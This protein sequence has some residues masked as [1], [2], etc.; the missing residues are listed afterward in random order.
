MQQAPRAVPGQTYGEAGAQIASQQVVPL[1][2]GGGMAPPTSGA[3]MPG[4]IDA[5]SARPNEPLTAG[6][7]QGA[8]PGP[9]ALDIPLPIEDPT[10]HILQGILSAHP[11]PDIQALLAQAQSSR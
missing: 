9:E 5:A 11:N 10:I 7:P 6:I 3:P 2:G 8:G 1:P 4:P